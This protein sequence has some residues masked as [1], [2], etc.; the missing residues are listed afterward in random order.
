MTRLTFDVPEEL[1][2]RIRKVAGEDPTAW[3]E[4][5]AR[6]ALLKQEATAVAEFEAGHADEAWERER[7]AA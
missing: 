5:V 3:F 2:A 4:A 7:W 6:D 1:A